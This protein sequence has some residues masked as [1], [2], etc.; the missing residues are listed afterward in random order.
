[1]SAL[2]SSTLTAYAASFIAAFFASSILYSIS[3]I[4]SL[5]LMVFLLAVLYLQIAVAAYQYI[6]G[7]VGTTVTPGD[8]SRMGLLLLLRM[9]AML[10]VLAL[11][12]EVVQF[13]IAVTPMSWQ[14][15]VILFE[16]AG[17]VIYVLFMKWNDLFTITFPSTPGE[18]V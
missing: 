2:D 7:G 17:F 1:M 12:L 16:V 3:H 11:L 8:R 14:E 15:Y 10:T 4:T 9:T 13:A 18:K 6:S 5:W